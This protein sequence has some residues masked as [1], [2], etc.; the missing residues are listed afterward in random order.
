MFFQDT[1]GYF[2]FCGR[3]DDMLKVGGMWVSPIEVEGGLLEHAAVLE[4]AVIGRRD[5]DGL[6]RAHAFCVL[7]DGFDGSPELEKELID[8]VRRRLAGYKAPRWIE[9]VADLP[10]TSTGKIQRFRLRAGRD[11]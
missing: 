2:Y 10:K 1:D 3:S 11:S 9:F 5:G 8:S 7:K 6:T 4:A